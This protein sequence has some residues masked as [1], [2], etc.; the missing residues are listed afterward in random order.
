MAKINTIIPTQNYELIRDRIAIILADEFQNQLFLTY[1]VDVDPVIFVERSN[2]F[3]KEE[4]PAVNVSMA[5]GNFANKNLGSSDGTYQFNIDFYTR[6]KSNAATGGD[7]ISTKKLHRM[8]GMARYILEDPIYKT[9]GFNPGFIMH[10]ICTEIIIKQLDKDDATNTAMG[11][12]IFTV[13]AN[14]SNRLLSPSIALGFDTKVTIEISNEGYY[15]VTNN[16]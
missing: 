13:K 6:S 8:I 10:T 12:L 4:L 5:V 16:Y 1:D 2:P 11:R 9:L 3:D 14:E 7:I 15:Y